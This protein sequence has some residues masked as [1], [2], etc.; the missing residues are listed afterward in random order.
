[1][2]ERMQSHILIAR[3]LQEFE[4][5]NGH[6]VIKRCQT[7]HA[8]QSCC[9]KSSSAQSASFEQLCLA[10]LVSSGSVL[11]LLTLALH[12]HAEET[13]TFFADACEMRGW[14]GVRAG[15]YDGLF[16]PR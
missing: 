7:P 1:M 4:V 10:C 16:S 13:G 12:A 11:L 3:Q 5:F 2:K 14:R 6:G 15:H 8:G 9:T